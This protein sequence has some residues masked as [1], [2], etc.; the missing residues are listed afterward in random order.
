MTERAARNSIPCRL[1]RA[2]RG[3][4]QDLANLRE[5]FLR[6]GLCR[7]IARDAFAPPYALGVEFL[8]RPR[9]VRFGF[10]TSADSLGALG[11]PIPYSPSATVGAGAASS[12]STSMLDRWRVRLDGRR[13]GGA[14]SGL[15]LLR[16]TG[17]EGSSRQPRLGRPGRH[18]R[19]WRLP[20]STARL[21]LERPRPRRDERDSGAVADA[22]LFLL[23]DLS[24]RQ[25]RDPNADGGAHASAQ[26]RAR[27]A[28]HIGAK[29]R[30]PD[31]PPVRARGR[32]GRSQLELAAAPSPIPFTVSRP[33]TAAPAHLRH[34][35]RAKTR[36]PPESLRARGRMRERSRPVARL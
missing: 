25:R 29:P 6:V 12:G 5:R 16:A 21:A 15:A 4:R 30:E 17:S 10:E 22:V 18:A 35:A 28:C 26:C 7:R 20:A 24:R 32:S 23:S 13:E 8:D 2:R 9:E 14:E 36:P 33:R 34:G 31:Q 11:R 3:L 27:P 19:G 1:A